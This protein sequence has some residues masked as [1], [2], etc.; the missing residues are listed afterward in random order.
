M[1]GDPLIRGGEIFVNT[2]VNGGGVYNGSL[3]LLSIAGGAWIYANTAQFDGGG[4]FNQA[5]LIVE[6]STLY[7]NS[8][9][10][11]G[12]FSNWGG[13][14]LLTSDVIQQNYASGKGGGFYVRRGR[15]TLTGGSLV[16][17]TCL[18]N[19]G[20]FNGAGWAPGFAPT[21]NGVTITNQSLSQDNNPP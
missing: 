19:P 13:D 3:S 20:S 17:N 12:G 7:L 1:G 18:V 16:G 2:A 11:G 21:L 5:E 9:T 8:A 4:V 10:S 15:V 14:A 6:A